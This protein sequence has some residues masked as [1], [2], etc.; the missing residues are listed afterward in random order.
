MHRSWTTGEAA[1][2]VWELASFRVWDDLVNEAGLPPE[3][4]TEV[5]TTSAIAALAAPVRRAR[6]RR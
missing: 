6:R 5:V 1:A 3:R 4:Y 2:L